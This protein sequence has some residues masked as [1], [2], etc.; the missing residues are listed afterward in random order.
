MTNETR[1]PRPPD[2]LSGYLDF[3]IGQV[4]GWLSHI[5]AA[6]ITQLALDQVRAGPRGDTCEIGVHHGKLFLILA[7]A[8][9]QGERAFAVDVFG[10]QEKNLDASGRGD[11]AIFERHLAA[12]APAAR[13]EIIQASSLDLER[14]GFLRNRFRLMSI[15]GGH[16]AAVTENDLRLAQGTLVPGGI[17]VLDDILSYDW[18]G[19]ITGLAAYLSRGGSLVPFALSPN[20]AYLAATAADA[21]RYR[22]ILRREFPLALSKENLEFLGASVDAYW[23]H[24]YYNRQDYAGLR[25]E[26]DDLKQECDALRLKADEMR[27]TVSGLQAELAAFRGSTSWR[28]TA[29]LRSLGTLR[30]RRPG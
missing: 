8:L 16:T 26:R 21:E 13:V 11:R 30:G 25:R 29:P 22:A 2:A 4:D 10:D 15:D 28:V 7:N 18:T 17:A 19:V 20:K 27:R 6:M 23:E 3:G 14:R 9:A 12:H 1:P 24:P 5:S